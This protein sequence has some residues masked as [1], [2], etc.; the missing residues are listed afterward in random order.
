MPRIRGYINPKAGWM[1]QGDR[2]DLRFKLPRPEL[3]TEQL[4]QRIC[5]PDNLELLPSEGLPKGKRRTVRVT[6]V[7]RN[8][9]GTCLIEGNLIIG[10]L[11]GRA[12]STESFTGEFNLA[13]GTGWITPTSSTGEL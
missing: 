10:F 9:D 1:R 4:I 3:T 2:Y 11:T 12:Q 7:K 6:E 5:N 13:I 8:E